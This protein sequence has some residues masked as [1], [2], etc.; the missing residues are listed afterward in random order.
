MSALDN[1]TEYH[2]QFTDDLKS[3]LDGLLHPDTISNDAASIQ[4]ISDFILN[5]LHL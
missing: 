1:I 3:Q 5:K 2:K 4:K